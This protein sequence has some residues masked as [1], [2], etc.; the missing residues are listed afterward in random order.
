MTLM[1]TNIRLLASLLTLGL[2]SVSPA[3]SDGTIS[4]TPPAGE[5]NASAKKEHDGKYLKQALE[6]RMQQLD[7][8]LKLT[9]EQKQKIKAIWE[10]QAAEL[11]DLTPEERRDRR[12]ETLMAIRNEVRGVLTPEQQKKFDSMKHEGGRPGKGRGKQP[13]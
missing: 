6:K 11:K 12:R 5:K 2:A 9:A 13:E 8:N 3:A 4:V 7:E 1:K 10:K